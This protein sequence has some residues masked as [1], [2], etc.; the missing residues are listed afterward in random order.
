MNLHHVVEAIGILVSGLLFYSY[1]Y[2]WLPTT[3]RGS[4]LW[5]ALLNG[6][7]FGGLAVVLMIARIEIAEGLFVDARAVP[8]ALIG[9]ITQ[10]STLAISNEL[11]KLALYTMGRE[12]TVDD[13]YELCSGDRETTTFSMIDAVQDGKTGDALHYLRRLREKDEVGQLLISMLST[14]YKQTAVIV[15]LM[16]N[17]ASEEEVGRAMGNAGKYPG[18]R[19][20]AM[21]R[22]IA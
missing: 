6:T 4:R 9:S 18:L 5:R 21:R 12:A 13:V 22:W 19:Q 15:E 17:G 7:G 3:R 20:P 10:G 2:S 16:D 14:R 1:T 8:V 11:D